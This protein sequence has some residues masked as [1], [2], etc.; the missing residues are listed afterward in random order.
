MHPKECPHAQEQD[1]RADEYNGECPHVPLRFADIFAGQVFLHHVLV[2]TSHGHGDKHAGQNVLDPVV[3]QTPIFRH[4]N[5]GQS[6]LVEYLRE[7]GPALASG[8]K[9]A[10]NGEHHSQKHACCLKGVR[11][12]HG[13]HS[14]F[15]GVR[16]NDGQHGCGGAH[17][18]TPGRGPARQRFEDENIQHQHNQEQTKRC[19]D[20]PAQQEKGSPR[21]VGLS[22]KSLA[23]VPV[24]AGQAKI[25]VKGE[26]NG[27]NNHVTNAVSRYHLKVGPLL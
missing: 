18:P 7:V 17:E 11:P 2:E 6:R 8:R 24:N 19:P 22:P 26:E 13:V 14:A 25:V 21:F 16:I 3:A 27:C 23:Q 12:D 10:P 20:D 4:P 1:V 5:A 9:D 15:A